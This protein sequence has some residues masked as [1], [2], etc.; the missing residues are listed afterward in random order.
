MPLT[1]TSDSPGNISSPLKEIPQEIATG[2]GLWGIQVP[3][4]WKVSVLPYIPD[5]KFYVKLDLQS[6]I[7]NS[8]LNH[9]TEGME[10]ILPAELLGN[11][12]LSDLERVSIEPEMT[13]DR[14]SVV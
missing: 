7:F 10:Q 3:G 1:P 2:L 9:P 12:F 14:K 13:L 8:L 4:D 6:I 5:N 11:P